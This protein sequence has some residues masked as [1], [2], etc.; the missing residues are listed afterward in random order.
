MT[1]KDPVSASSGG[2]TTPSVNVMYHDVSV[3][4]KDP[5]SASSGGSTTPSVNVMYHD[6]SVKD[7]VSASNGGSTTPSAPASGKKG[8]KSRG[9]DAATDSGNGDAGT[10]EN[11][12]PV[13]HSRAVILACAIH[14]LAQQHRHL[15]AEHTI[16]YC[17]STP[18]AIKNVQVLFLG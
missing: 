6:V 10:V 1:V 14:L 7:P 11:S 4:V 8:K 12:E 9:K 18:W 16:C 3:S 17:N 13:S 15:Y 5:V 2:S